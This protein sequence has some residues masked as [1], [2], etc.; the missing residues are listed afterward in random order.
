MFTSMHRMK[1]TL[2]KMTVFND[3]LNDIS[4][5]FEVGCVP[6]IDACQ[7]VNELLEQIVI[8]N[9]LTVCQNNWTH[10]PTITIQHEC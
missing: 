7:R 10:T 3:P 6:F 5:A 1:R 8:A 4:I 2:N 9:I